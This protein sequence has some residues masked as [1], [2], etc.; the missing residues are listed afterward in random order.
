[1][2]RATFTI[3]RL[4]WALF[5][6]GQEEEHWRG[7]YL[8]FPENGLDFRSVGCSERQTPQGYCISC[9]LPVRG[10]HVLWHTCCLCICM[11]S[12]TSWTVEATN[13][14]YWSTST[15]LAISQA[16]QALSI[17]G[18]YLSLGKWQGNINPYRELAPISVDVT[19]PHYSVSSRMGCQFAVRE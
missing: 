11:W 12:N 1:M 10:K 8:G 6:T 15:W 3:I 17:T 18:S 14:V 9:L 4:K 16:S 7:P 13:F 5:S 19:K 2:S